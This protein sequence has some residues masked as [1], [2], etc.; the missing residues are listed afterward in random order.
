MF[1]DDVVS[2]INNKVI[3]RDPGRRMANY[4][5]GRGGLCKDKVA[6]LGRDWPLT[7]IRNFAHDLMPLEVLDQSIARLHGVHDAMG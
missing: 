5:S 3:S 6:P 2:T 7:A 4:A 1:C